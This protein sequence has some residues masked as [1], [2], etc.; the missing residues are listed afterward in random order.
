MPGGVEEENSLHIS[1]G[2]KR[3][4]SRRFFLT[5]RQLN[6]LAGMIALSVMGMV[7]VED[8]AF[9]VFSLAYIHFLS[10]VA[11][12]PLSPRP[13]PRVFGE[14]N[15][16][17]DLYVLFSGIISLAFP[18]AYILE[19]MFRGYKEG[20]RV[21]A[22]H[23]FLLASQIFMEGVAFYGGFSM[24]VFAFVPVFY[25]S[26]RIFT[27]A[28][29][30][31]SE[32]YKTD[33]NPRRLYIGRGLAVVNMA[34]WCFNLFGFLLPVFLPRVFKVYYSSGHRDEH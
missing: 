14:K 8:L 12:P 4:Q 34:F 2:K 15:R 21:A 20:V 16:L 11:F 17:Q 32:F 19:G 28:D 26:R 18:S 27:V 1:N 31:R 10:K 13:N 9:V 25:N 7:S 5:F 30:L 22:S 3:P 33:E 24:P 29:W 6:A 23:V